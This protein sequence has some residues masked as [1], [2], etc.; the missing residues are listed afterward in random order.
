MCGLRQYLV[1]AICPDT[2]SYY[3]CNP[4]MFVCCAIYFLPVIEASAR[5]FV[6]LCLE[7]CY[8]WRGGSG[9]DPRKL[10]SD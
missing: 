5:V 3:S 10:Q 6:P 7:C 4:P 2:T 1:F 8:Y 9:F